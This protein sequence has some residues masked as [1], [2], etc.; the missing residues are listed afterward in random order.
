MSNPT[1]ISFDN[2]EAA[3][4]YKTNSEL[5]KAHFLFSSMGNI[6]LVK[7]G[8]VLI[9]KLI[10]WRVPFAK[11]IIKN[12]IFNQFV[13]GE[14]LEQTSDVV[15]KLETHK[16]NV[17]LDYGVEGGEGENS[18]AQAAE[19]FIKV[20]KFAS[21]QSNIPFISIK[22]T[23][24]SR[25]G[26]LEKIHSI[27]LQEGC[28]SIF[29]RYRSAIEKISF[30]EKNEW[31]KVT[32]RLEKIC[33]NASLKKVAVLVDAEESWI[34]EPV[35]AIT[36]EMMK[37][38]NKTENLVY[39]T[40]QLYRY[41]RFSFLKY[42]LEEACQHHFI[43]GA[44]LVRG[45]YMEKERKRAAAMNYLSPIQISKENTDNDYDNAIKFCIENIDKIAFIVASHNGKSNLLAATLMLE[46]GLP[47]NHSH[48]HFSQL[49]GMS[50]DITFNLASSG[51]GVSKYLPF[52]PISDVIP[53]LMR[54]AEENSAVS[55]QTGREL[56]LIKKE[57]KRRKTD[58]Q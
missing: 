28:Q 56:S 30:E 36:M 20:I 4:A 32:K 48:I 26:L 39:N 19:E 9:P 45:A 27:M 31:K 17:I 40:I 25:F 22:I 5:K 15:K 2:S 41:D 50:D 35:D 29:D 14:S 46:K 42:S 54:R 3:F 10:K 49:Y 23:G 8:L 57:L 7:L 6:F 1:P 53:Y 24:I 47:S 55:G 43:F 21:T 44:K 34:Q 52:G 11:K 18:F 51:F 12:T 58:R 16:V 37:K 38:Y 13:G 33:E